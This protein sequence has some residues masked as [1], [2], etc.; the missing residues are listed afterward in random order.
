MPVC[1]A[2]NQEERRSL[3][4]TTVQHG[5]LALPSAHRTSSPHKKRR[6]Q[7]TCWLSMRQQQ[8]C[9][10]DADRRAVRQK[11]RT[12]PCPHERTF[13]VLPV[14]SSSFQVEALSIRQIFANYRERADVEQCIC[15]LQF[16]RGEDGRHYTGRRMEEFYFTCARPDFTALELPS[17]GWSTVVPQSHSI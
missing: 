14:R 11:R 15:N 12:R 10:A 3:L 5:L 17:L 8:V 6:I 13:V 16:G 7:K 4:G 9:R 1:N 2:R